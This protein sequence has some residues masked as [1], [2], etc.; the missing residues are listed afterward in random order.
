MKYYIISHLPTGNI[1]PQV[2]ARRGQTAMSFQPPEKCAPR[3]WRTEGYARRWLTVYCKGELMSGPHD[4]ICTRHG[5]LNILPGT[6]RNR[7]EYAILAVRISN[8]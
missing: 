4:P 8:V 2:I 3:L 6:A 1:F 5:H 7:S